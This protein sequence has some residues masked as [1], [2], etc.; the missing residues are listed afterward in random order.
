M[1]FSNQYEADLSGSFD[2]NNR[3]IFC[4][5]YKGYPLFAEK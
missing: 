5:R 3:I 4:C 2:F 1:S